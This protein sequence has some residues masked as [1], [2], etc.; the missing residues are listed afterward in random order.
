MIASLF[1]NFISIYRVVFVYLSFIPGGIDT[2]VTTDTVDDILVVLTFRDPKLVHNISSASM[3]SYMSN[4]KFG[5][6]FPLIIPR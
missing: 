1:T 6:C 5:I 2:L 3:I 4:G